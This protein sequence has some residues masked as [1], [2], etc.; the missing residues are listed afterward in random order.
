MV[1]P[2]ALLCSPPTTP[3]LSIQK[4]NP[5]PKTPRDSIFLPVQA[6]FPAL[7]PCSTHTKRKSAVRLYSKTMATAPSGSI[8]CR[9]SDIFTLPPDRRMNPLS[10]KLHTPC[11]VKITSRHPSSS[12]SHTPMH[13]TESPSHVRAAVE[14]VLPPG[15]KKRR[16]KKYEADHP[17]RTKASTLPLL[18]KS[19]ADVCAVYNKIDLSLDDCDVYEDISWIPKNEVFNTSSPIRVTWKGS[20]LKISHL[21]FYERLHSGEVHIASTLRLTP[22]QFLRCKRTLI[23]AAYQ[24]AKSGL[25]LRKS[26]AQK[27]CR[28]DV[29]KTSTLWS[30]FHQLGWFCPPSSPV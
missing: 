6:S 15:Q 22:E 28:I 8:T 12:L 25:Q 19:K 10:S 14:R 3:K 5:A 21:P 23:L 24:R 20:H 9:G 30:V 13:Y 7:A 26:D 17:K 29:N 18:K 16:G 4:E 27:L 11:L 2:L 1:E